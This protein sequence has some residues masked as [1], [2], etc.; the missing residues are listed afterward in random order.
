MG[1][2]VLGV[3]LGVVSGLVPLYIAEVRG[4]KGRE[5]TGGSGGEGQVFAIDALPCSAVSWVIA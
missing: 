5:G 3:G 2:A 1:R 4:R